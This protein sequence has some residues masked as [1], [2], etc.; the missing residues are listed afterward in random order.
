M[1][2]HVG[3]SKPPKR[4]A[5]G[6]FQRY[7]L[8]DGIHE[9]YSSTRTDAP[10]RQ[11]CSFWCQLPRI[12]LY[13]GNVAGIGERQGRKYLQGK[14]L[15][16]LRRQRQRDRAHISRAHDIADDHRLA[17]LTGC[18]AAGTAERALAELARALRA[19]ERSRDGG[20]VREV[21][22]QPKGVDFR[23]LDYN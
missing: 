23:V 12:I 3:S 15:F 18:V 5:N 20:A 11:L 22:V 9:I 1:N 2:T 10:D 21:S 4:V 16:Y 6:R 8:M 17:D 14:I 13:A 19:A 7:T